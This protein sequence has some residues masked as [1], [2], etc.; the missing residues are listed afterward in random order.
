MDVLIDTPRLQM[1]QFRIEDAQAVFDFNADTHVTRYTGDAGLVKTLDD[2]K[3]IITDIWLRDYAKYGYG[4]YALIH[5]ADQKLIG[6][7]GLKYDPGHPGT[8]LGYRMLPAYWGQGLGFEAAKAAFNYG[9]DTLKLNH[10]IAEADENNIGSIKIIER[11][12]FTLC[13]QYEKW[14][15]PLLRYEYTRPTSQYKNK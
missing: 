10:I 15:H 7:C 13:D 3:K 14:G 5:K 1:R 6:F 4:R 8:D 11:L 2:A 12:G 9:L